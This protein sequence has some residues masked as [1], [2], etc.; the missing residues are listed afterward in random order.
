MWYWWSLS[1][2]SSSF[3]VF[4]SIKEKIKHLTPKQCKFCLFILIKNYH[5]HLTVISCTLLKIPKISFVKTQKN[6]SF[7]LILAN[8]SD[9]KTGE[10]KKPKTTGKR[11]W[12]FADDILK[13]L[14]LT[15]PYRQTVNGGGATMRARVSKRGKAGLGPIKPTLTCGW[16]HKNIQI[17][18]LN[19]SAFYA[20]V[21]WALMYK[22]WFVLS[23]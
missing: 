1:T 6:I 8:K 4:F 14:K 2:L 15:R 21:F 17:F 9:N 5:V 19:L 11:V 13:S 22:P 3:S 23:T 10:P 7:F 18:I 20:F 16:H 12:L